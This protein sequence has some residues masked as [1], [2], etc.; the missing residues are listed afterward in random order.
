MMTPGEVASIASIAFGIGCGG[1]A[2][3]I[4][5]T[6]SDTIIQRLNGRYVAGGICRERHD[7]LA[8]QL[9]RIE[10]GSEQL[11]HKVERGFE[12]LNSQL[13]AAQNARD[14]IEQHQILRERTAKSGAED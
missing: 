9:A 4:R 11:S 6:I 10:R 14:S 2:L 8:L 13:F 5:S 7:S 12:S 3:Y 1:V